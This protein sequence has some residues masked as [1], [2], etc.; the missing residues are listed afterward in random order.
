MQDPCC[1]SL[2]NILIDWLQKRL[3]SRAICGRWML[4]MHQNKVGVA[5]WWAGQSHYFIDDIRMQLFHTTVWCLTGLKAF[6]LT[7]CLFL[8]SRSSFLFHPGFKVVNLLI[9]SVVWKLMNAAD[10]CNSRPIGETHTETE[11]L[12]CDLINIPI[13]FWWIMFVLYS[14]RVSIKLNDFG[15]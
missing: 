7:L 1:L 5:P 14:L 11:E 9:A 2:L 4:L 3:I 6:C 8:T 15:Y 13:I 10:T 12:L